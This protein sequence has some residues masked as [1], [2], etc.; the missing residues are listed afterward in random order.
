MKKFLAL[1]TGTPADEKF[2]AYMAMPEADRQK[3]FAAGMA[4]WKQWQETYKDSILDS[5]GPLGRTLKADMGG[6]TEGG[7]NL[8]GYSI[9]QAESLE[10][11]A[12]MFENHPHFAIFPG[13]AVEIMPILDQPTPEQKDL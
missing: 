9:V 10:Q 3:T 2:K 1:M 12:K 8:S 7:N 11:A 5:G 13:V 4:A 6:V